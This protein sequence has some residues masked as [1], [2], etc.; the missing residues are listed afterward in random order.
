[1]LPSLASPVLP[2]PSFSP[3]PILCAP[4]SPPRPGRI[5]RFARFGSAR[6]LLLTQRPQFSLSLEM[7]G[8]TSSRLPG[9]NQITRPV[10]FHSLP[11]H[12]NNNPVHL[13]PYSHRRP[14]TPRSSPLAGPSLSSD[15]VDTG[16]GDDEGDKKPKYRPNRIS[17]T[18]DMVLPIQSVYGSDSTSHSSPSTSPPSTISIGTVDVVLS[19]TPIPRQRPRTAPSSEDGR[20]KEEAEDGGRRRSL[21]E[22]LSII[23]ASSS[24]TSHEK[25]KDGQKAADKRP[26]SF[27]LPSTSTTSLASTS[28]SRTV[29]TDKTSHTIPPIPT[30]PQWALNAMREEEAGANRNMK[31]GH[32]RGTSDDIANWSTLP[33]PPLPN[34]PIPRGVRTSGLSNQPRPPSISRDPGENWM[35]ATDPIPKFSRLGLR[36][37]AVIMPVSKKEGLAKIR[38]SGSI[39][40]TASPATLSRHADVKGDSG[41]TSKME[42]S[43]T[44]GSN[45]DSDAAGAGA[46][47]KVKEGL[48]KR[49]SLASSLRAKISKTILSS[50]AASEDA[51]PLPPFTRKSDSSLT[52]GMTWHTPRPTSSDSASKTNPTRRSVASRRNSSALT[53]ID[54][55]QPPLPDDAYTEFGRKAGD[56]KSQDTKAKRRSIKQ[57]VM[58]ITTSPMSAGEKM[59]LGRIRHSPSMPVVTLSPDTLEPLEPPP[60]TRFGKL[61]SSSVS[62]LPS[63]KEG[64][65]FACGRGDGV[66]FKSVRKRWNT[67]LGAVKG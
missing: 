27:I 29:R 60:G 51:L 25:D 57:I 38:S 12:H 26:S 19:S 7:N 53:A 17:S 31:Y 21:A 11:E 14:R 42:P 1:M 24:A 9:R 54:E 4:S 13:S 37:D 10:S 47:L 20:A 65:G 62:S 64:S 40:N 46:N 33:L 45:N 2:S 48:R 67:V 3:P 6:R 22:R 63:T 58:R 23:C 43:F 15:Q 49:P 52:S 41:V 39:R 55:N 61:R 66:K 50:S 30:I 28:S 35:S 36:G 5:V 56:V 32:R 44:A 8:G 18:P 34:Q 59:K 16:N